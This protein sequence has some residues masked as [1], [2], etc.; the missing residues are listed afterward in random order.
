LIALASCGPKRQAKSTI[1]AFIKENISEKSHYSIEDYGRLDSTRYL[2]DSIISIMHTNAE[3][4]KAFGNNLQYGKR[5]D[6]KKQLKYIPIKMKVY[7]QDTTYIFYLT[8]DLQQ[9]VAFK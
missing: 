8:N 3:K 4:N 6:K 5:K 2:T 7:D 9:V 1:K